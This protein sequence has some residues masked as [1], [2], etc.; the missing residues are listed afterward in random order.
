LAKEA[1]PMTS[2]TGSGNRTRLP[3]AGVTTYTCPMH[4]EI[5]RPSPGKCPK[6]GMDLV[7]KT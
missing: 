2:H 1:G 7:P 5:E 3:E 6:C 4:P